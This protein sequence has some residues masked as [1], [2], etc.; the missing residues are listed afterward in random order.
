[1]KMFLAFSLLLVT[2][3]SQGCANYEWLLEETIHRDRDDG[4]TIRVE[5]NYPW[6]W[7]R[8]RLA[9]G[10]NNV[11]GWKRTILI[12]NARIQG[13][14]IY[15]DYRVNSP[16]ILGWPQT[17]KINKDP[18][19]CIGW[20]HQYN[21]NYYQVIGEWVLNGDSMQTL[22]TFRSHRGGNDYKF[23]EPLRTF[24][25]KSGDVFWVFVC[26]LNWAGV[27]SVQER[28]NLLKVVYP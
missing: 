21:G 11:G 5:E 8:V 20:V 18:N 2:L 12:E 28:S 26:G 10:D 27:G 1:M 7:D 22:K 6:D 19:A 13:G 15:W 14:N 25:P 17:R 23:H 4:N 16:K 3:L 24:K 9:C